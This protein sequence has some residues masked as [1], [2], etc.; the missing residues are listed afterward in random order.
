MR[1]WHLPRRAPFR[2][3]AARGRAEGVGGRLMQK[4]AVAGKWLPEVLSQAGRIL[5]QTWRHLVPAPGGPC[6]SLGPGVWAFFQHR[7]PLATGHGMETETGPP[8]KDTR[9]RPGAL[10]RRKKMPPHVHPQGTPRK[11]IASLPEALRSEGTQGGGAAPAGLQAG[12]TEHPLPALRRPSALCA[13]RATGHRLSSRTGPDPLREVTAPQA[14]RPC[15]PGVLA[16][17]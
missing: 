12:S 4:C 11:E 14:P 10:Q 1:P 3:A 13:V 9:G 16:R 2:S 17:T 6:R 5:S 8:P 15:A 7:S